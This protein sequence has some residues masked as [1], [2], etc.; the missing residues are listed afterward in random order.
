MPFRHH[1][2]LQ[3]HCEELVHCDVGIVDVLET[4]ALLLQSGGTLAHLHADPDAVRQL[5]VPL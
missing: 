5:P 2:L 1:E 3:G 4:V